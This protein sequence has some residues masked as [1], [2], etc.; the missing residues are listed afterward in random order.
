MGS[1]FFLGTLCIK[2]F[3]KNTNKVEKLKKMSNVKNS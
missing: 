2:T 3:F 1:S